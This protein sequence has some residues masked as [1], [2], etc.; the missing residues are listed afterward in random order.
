MLIASAS[1]TCE[2][3]RLKLEFSKVRNPTYTSGISIYDGSVFLHF[4][5]DSYTLDWRIDKNFDLSPQAANGLVTFTF[6]D[7]G[8]ENGAYK[9]V[10]KTDETCYFDIDVANYTYL[11]ENYVV[12][13]NIYFIDDSDTG[14][15]YQA[16]SIKLMVDVITTSTTTTSI[17]GTTTTTVGERCPDNICQNEKQFYWSVKDL[18]N[19]GNPEL[20]QDLDI[21]QISGGFYMWTPFAGVSFDLNLTKWQNKLPRSLGYLFYNYKGSTIGGIENWDVSGV[22][23]FIESFKGATNLEADLSCWRVGGYG[24]SS[25]ILERAFVNNMFEGATN[26]QF[27]A[28]RWLTQEKFTNG[29]TENCRP[30]E[31]GCDLKPCDEPGYGEGCPDGQ[32]QNAL[33]LRIELELCKYDFYDCQAENLDIS[34]IQD[35]F[36]L[37][38][39]IPNYQ[40]EFFLFT[41]GI[42]KNLNLSNWGQNLPSNLSYLFS[43][44]QTDYIG[45]VSGIDTWNVAQVVDM[46]HMLRDSDINLDLSSWD[47]RNVQ[48][49]NQMFYD[50]E[51]FGSNLSSWIVSSVVDMESMFYLARSFESDLSDWDVSSVVNMRQMFEGAE[52]FE[53]DLSG[54]DVSSVVNMR[55]MFK[56][57]EAF[58]SDLSGWDVSSVVNMRQMFEGANEFESDLSCW[59][60]QASIYRMFNESFF[61][62]Q[63]LNNWRPSDVSIVN[64][65]E[66]C[67]P[68]ESGCANPGCP[69]TSETDQTLLIVG[70]VLTVVVLSGAVYFTI[71]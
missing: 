4:D 5:G 57:A 33:Q 30:Y 55:Q 65:A 32:C 67:G 34:G 48:F 63:N 54:W 62:T 9:L 15:K 16:K 18:I 20:I 71:M 64:L 13:D 39:Y 38:D 17:T 26:L 40:S 12:N 24:Q 31:K 29:L 47:V 11:D 69:L 41:Y 53:S 10:I 49:M 21:S 8:F 28:N 52:A 3:K 6:P 68:G 22:N 61:L 23:D 44:G 25:I 50:H 36:Y 51:S 43:D 66:G 37:K 7:N 35:G 14:I 42:Q 27:N 70:M 60:V 58:K 2:P 46:R 19:A 59:N 45:N 1:S 56:G